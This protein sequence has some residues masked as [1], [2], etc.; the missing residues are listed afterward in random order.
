MSTFKFHESP[1]F[2]LN[3]KLE[4]MDNIEFPIFGNLS[5]NS[6]CEYEDNFNYYSEIDVKNLMKDLR[7]SFH[8]KKEKFD[9]ENYIIRKNY[10]EEALKS[11]QKVKDNF[12][13]AKSKV[14]LNKAPLSFDNLSKEIENLYYNL[15]SK[16]I[17]LNTTECY[18]DNRVG[19]NRYEIQID[20][21]K[22]K[23]SYNY[24]IHF[25]GADKH[26]AI[27][28]KTSDEN[29]LFFFLQKVYGK[30]EV[31]NLKEAISKEFIKRLTEIESLLNI[32]ALVFLYDKLPTYIKIAATEK[33]KGEKS[34]K[35]PDVLLWKHFILFVEYDVGNR[36]ASYYVIYLMTLMTPKYCIQK[37]REDQRLVI[38]V[39]DGLD[40]RND[41]ERYFGDH[42][43]SETFGIDENTLA[44][45]NKDA[46]VTLLNSYIQL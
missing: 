19:G 39:Y 2:W 12:G 5:N 44:P 3:K 24:T 8:F 20:T 41:V 26:P 15:L 10:R 7:S 27:L 38:Q 9:A 6:D 32:K 46:F 29:L 4:A 30:Q 28:L 13:L 45:S 18:L 1:D 23:I 34:Y 16:S 40:D 37:F 43:F 33:K 42:P 21:S 14:H 36:D 11:G 25:K 35:I 31:N 22:K 17:A